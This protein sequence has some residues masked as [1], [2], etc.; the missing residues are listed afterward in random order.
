MYRGYDFIPHGTRIDF[1]GTRRVALA[2]SVL[3]MVGSI[4]AVV[5][6]GLNF[7]IDFAGGILVEART[8]GAADLGALRSKLNALDVGEVELQGVVGADN[9]VIIRLQQPKN[10]TEATQNAVLAKVRAALGGT[11]DI[12]RTELVG[13]KVGGELIKSGAWATGLAILAI[14][15]YVWFRFEWQ[16]GLGGML[17][18]LHDVVTTIGLFA[19]T[20]MEFNLTSV[21][22]V[23]TIAGYS[24]NDSVVVYDRVRE[25]LRKYKKMP[26]EDLLNL[27]TNETLSRTILTSGTTALVVVALLAFGGDVLWGFAVAMLWGLVAGTYSS[28][29]IGVPVLLFF[30]V[31]RGGEGAD[32]LKGG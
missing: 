29:Y 13:P 25:N 4:L 12:R 22:A 8:D 30:N 16:F 2:G 32:S 24:I 31:L 9:A 20:R 1:V 6:L 26:L 18:L 7:G 15:A 5:F 21:A 27:S 10:T 14:A 3:A 17:A 28:I 19:V 23:L 11:V